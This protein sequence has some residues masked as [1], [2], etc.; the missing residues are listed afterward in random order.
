MKSHLRIQLAAGLVLCAACWDM[1]QNALAQI[2]VANNGGGN[3]GI[4]GEYTISGATINASL[5]SDLNLP[6][7]LAISGGNLYEANAAGTIGEYNLATGAAINPALIT[8]VVT[9]TVGIAISGGDI[10]VAGANNVIGDNNVGEYTISGAPVKTRLVSGLS[11]PSF[12]AVSG[13]DIYVASY[14]D[15][16]GTIGE[17]NAANG[18]TINASLVSGLNNPWGIVVSGGDIY[19]ANSGSGTIGEYDAAT[20]ATINAALVSGLNDPIGLAISGGDIFV[21][22]DTTIGEYDAT[23]GAPIN[24][25]LVTGLQDATG[26]LVVAPE[27][28]AG[29]IAG[30]GLLAIGLC[31][32][33]RRLISRMAPAPSSSNRPRLFSIAGPVVG[34]RRIIFL[35]RRRPR[36]CAR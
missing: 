35:R 36:L 34:L 30:L 33:F 9:S 8:P 12:L 18:A 11:E 15:G 16:N 1:P 17:Y 2:Y 14:N 28:P 20:G 3:D 6:Y 13:G 5:V 32:T 27:P 10:F 31:K 22:S 29:I 7:G 19:V 4:I 25:A 21:T 26:L 24:T 23:T